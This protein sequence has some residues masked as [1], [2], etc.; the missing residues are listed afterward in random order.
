MDNR[1][2]YSIFAG[3]LPPLLGMGLIELYVVREV[4]ITL[5][6]AALVGLGILMVVISALVDVADTGRQVVGRRRRHRAR[7]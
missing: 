6:V 1:R 4:S 2:L 3:I 5:I 7:S